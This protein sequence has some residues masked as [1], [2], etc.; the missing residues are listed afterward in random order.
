MPNDNTDP[1]GLHE[2]WTTANAARDSILARYDIIAFKSCYHPTC[3][4]Y[5]DEQLQQYKDWY[6]EIRDVLDQHPEKLF[7][8]MS[9][10]PLH[11]LV[12]EVEWADR[13]RDYSEWLGSDEFLAGHP[14]IVYFDFFDRLAN[15]DDGSPTR[16]MLR[17]EYEITHDTPNGHPNALANGI[18]GPQFAHFVVSSAN[19]MQSVDVPVVDAGLNLAAYPN[20]FNP[21]TAIRFELPE[22][23][24]VRLDIFDLTGRLVRSLHNGSLAAGTHEMTWQ[25]RDDAGRSLPSGTFYCRLIAGNAISSTPLTLLK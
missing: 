19:R 9:P 8:V 24:T 20:P 21:R 18:V 11:R 12:T 16:N 3:A 4:I 22:A 1:D 25:G 23:R 14:N 6:L 15:P 5:T 2:L 7:I 10:P 17:W 13:A